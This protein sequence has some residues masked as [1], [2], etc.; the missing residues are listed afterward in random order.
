PVFV[1]EWRPVVEGKQWQIVGI[2]FNCQ[3]DFD[4][5]TLDDDHDDYLWIDPL[6]Y[7]KYNLIKD[8]SPV[9]EAYLNQ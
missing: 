6:D 3:T 7:K 2:F 1:N 8:L 9:F 4:Q 5:V